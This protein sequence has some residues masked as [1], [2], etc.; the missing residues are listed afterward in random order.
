[1]PW[2]Q[3]SPMDQRIQFISDFLRH[4]LS[5]TD[6]CDLYG[7]SRKTGYKWI[8]RYL[9][10][11]PEGLVE[12]SR[13]PACAP[14]AT[15]QEIV[16]AFIEVR[17]RH[18]S[19]GAKKLLAI[20]HQRH[21]R[22]DLPGR[23]TVCDILK[24]HGMVPKKRYRRHI[25]HPG[26]PTSQILAPNE[27]WSADFKGQF[28]TGDGHYC[29]PLTVTDGFSRF[30]LGCQALSSTSVAQAKPVFT[31]LF[32]EF[33]LPRRIRTDNGVPFATNTLGRL[34]TLSA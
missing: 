33:G 20:V 7:V 27:V 12:R 4:S 6:L 23:S 26:K 8:D 31:R 9:R 3:T 32:K 10:L 18:P 28:K 29:Y 17:Q 22:W 2:R 34:S 24:R 11:G 14:N 19:W 13:R 16:G 15:S 25:G 5:T 1:M 30:L 21:P